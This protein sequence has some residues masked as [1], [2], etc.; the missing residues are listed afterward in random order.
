MLDTIV[1]AEVI[2][3]CTVLAMAL[4]SFGCVVAERPA[5]HRP[6][7][8]RS[9]CTCGHTLRARDL[10]PVLSWLARGGRAACCGAPIPVRYVVTELVAGLLGAVLGIAVR[11]H[12]SPGHAAMPLLAAGLG[13]AAIFAGVVRT[14]WQPIWHHLDQETG[15]IR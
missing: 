9:T 7:T 2:P 12:T 3:A 5:Q 14:N 1:R 8:G 4:A 15:E 6:V 11:A 13:L 10:I